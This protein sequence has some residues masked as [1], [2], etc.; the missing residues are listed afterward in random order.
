MLV[1]ESKNFTDN[2]NAHLLK[3]SIEV[4]KLDWKRLFQ[5][6]SARS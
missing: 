2:T 6:G 3:V 4:S 1:F 5:F